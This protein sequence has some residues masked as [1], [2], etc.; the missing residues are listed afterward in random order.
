MYHGF[1]T[2][3]NYIFSNV[4]FFVCL[5]LE[6]Q[7]IVI[8]FHNITVFT[9]FFYQINAALVSIRIF[10]HKHYKNLTSTNF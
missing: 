6:H 3:I 10:F 4:S 5:F 7:I 1:N 2:N 9:V 8:I